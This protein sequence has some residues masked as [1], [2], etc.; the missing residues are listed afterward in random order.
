M[1]KFLLK[2]TTAIVMLTLLVITTIWPTMA[3]ADQDTS[4]KTLLALG[5]SLTTGYGLDQYTY[6]G[7][8]YLCDSYIN[9]IAAAMGLEGGKSYINRAVNG[10]T[11]SDLA[12]LIPTLE[13]EVKDAELIIITIGGN[14][15]LGM[16]PSIAQRL[17][18][19]P[20]TNFVQAV[21]IFSGVSAE[22]YEALKNDPAFVA[23]MQT[24][25]EDLTAN[26]QTIAD[27]ISEKSPDARVI[28]LKQYN[29]IHNLPRFEAFGDFSGEFLHS[30]NEI[31]ESVATSF[32]YET[33]DVP[34]VIDERAM[35]LTN[36]LS[37]DIHPNAL[38]HLEIAKVVAEHLGLS[39]DLPEETEN[40]TDATAEAQ[41]EA[42]NS[43]QETQK[44]E[45]PTAVGETDSSTERKG[46]AASAGPLSGLLLSL[47]AAFAVKKRH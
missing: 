3:I 35:M 29:P 25:L 39:L 17:S 23:Q 24:V 33:V 44:E 34:S 14:D 28:F 30:M 5:D 10:D 9:R 6:G 7:D 41:T 2:S 20:V 26:L 47:C 31:L 18:G 22:K 4:P 37:Y 12:R 42:P 15:L 38:G 32:G 40:A 8:P 36:I 13:N 19:K 46:C 11:S 1:K 43:P 21:Q 45:S 27:F 16:L